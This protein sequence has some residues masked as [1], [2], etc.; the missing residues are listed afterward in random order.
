VITRE[1]Y[2]E[3]DH[4]MRGSLT[5]ILGEAELVLAHGE[6]PDAERRRSVESVVMAVRQMEDLLV[7]WRA[8][9]A[10]GPR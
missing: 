3:F 2:A 10:G 1:M 8:V 7:E 4:A 5:V 6:V 9:A